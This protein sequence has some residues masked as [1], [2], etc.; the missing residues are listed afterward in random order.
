MRIFVS[1][2]V[3]LLSISYS[4]A[5][6]RLPGMLQAGEALPDYLGDNNDSERELTET[7]QGKIILLSFW[8][9]DCSVCM[10]EIGY[11]ESFQKSV[12]KEK[13]SVIAINHGDNGRTYRRLMKQLGDVT[14]TFTQ[15]E[16]KGLGQRRFGVK[17]LPFMMIADEQGRVITAYSEYES[18]NINQ[19]AADLN[20]VFQSAPAQ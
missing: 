2:L 7:H 5:Q 16:N 17:R 19:V 10:E 15:D 14:L 3:L 4:V 11:L 1:I 12:G 18:G 9:T 6:D 8:N 20:A 13:L